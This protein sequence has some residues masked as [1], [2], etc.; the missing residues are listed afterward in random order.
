MVPATFWNLPAGALAA[1]L[2]QRR[3][4]AGAVVPFYRPAAP[5]RAVALSR[6]RTRLTFRG[7]DDF[8]P[9]FRAAR[10]AVIAEHGAHWWAN[11]NVCRKGQ[12][13]KAWVTWKG[14]ASSGSSYRDLNMP[15]GRYWPGGEMPMGP[16]YA[17]PIS[18]AQFVEPAPR[19]HLTIDVPAWEWLADAAD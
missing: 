19:R 1:H 12:V 2:Q 16:A 15:M 11:P 8:M 3:Q 14:R 18:V 13:P 10:A 6:P 9:A 7:F 5:G 17:G 4:D